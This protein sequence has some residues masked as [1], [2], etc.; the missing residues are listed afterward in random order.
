MRNLYFLFQT[1]TMVVFGEQ[2]RSRSSALLSL[3]PNS[4][5][6]EIPNGRH[7]AYLDD[8]NLWHQ[9]MYNFLCEVANSHDEK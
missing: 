4:Q 5:C 3:L 2:D 6:Q 7:P 1:P 8:P 9:L